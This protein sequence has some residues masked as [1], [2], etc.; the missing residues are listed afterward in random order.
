MPRR[1]LLDWTP[2]DGPQ[3]EWLARW[4]EQG[5]EPEYGY[6]VDL[7][8]HPGAWVR[9]WAMVWKGE[10]RTAPSQQTT[11]VRSWERTVSGAAFWNWTVTR[12]AGV[13][14]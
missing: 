6:G 14:R 10:S 5:W 3:D 1:T 13:D 11:R 8:L 12:E 9:R 7:E 2:D 4:A